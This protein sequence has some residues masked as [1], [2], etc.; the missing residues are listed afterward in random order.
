[1]FSQFKISKGLRINKLIVILFLLFSIQNNA[2]LLS[3]DNLET[4]ARE[5]AMANSTVASAGSS[6][7]FQNPAGTAFLSSTMAGIHF[8]NLYQIP[9]LGNRGIVLG[10]PTKFGSFG[11]KGFYFG[12]VNYNKQKYTFNYARVFGDKLCAGIS[13]NYFHS[14]LKTGYEEARTLAGEV[15]FIVLPTENLSIGCHVFNISNSDYNENS[16]QELPVYMKTGIAWQ[17]EKFALTGQ[18]QI[19]KKENTSFSVGTEVYLVPDLA[20]R[21]GTSTVQQY[22]YTFGIGYKLTGIN[23][24]IAFARHPVLGFSYFLTLEYYFARKK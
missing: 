17:A 24:N 23:G 4:D 7:G 15:G 13:F 11:L 14:T 8:E 20:I 10:V 9:Q 19:N 2:F 18:V 16:G 1:M 5:S 12:S 22:N 3:Q 21:F 6:H